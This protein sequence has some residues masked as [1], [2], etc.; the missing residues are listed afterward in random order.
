MSITR[1][2]SDQ[3]VIAVSK[4]NNFV[5]NDNFNIG[6]KFTLKKIYI[7]YTVLL[8]TKDNYAK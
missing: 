3:D 8:Y 2:V 6:I 7:Q 5:R 4:T 1:C